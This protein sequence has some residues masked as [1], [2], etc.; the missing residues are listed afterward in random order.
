MIYPAVVRFD[1]QRV[2]QLHVEADP[3]LHRAQ[4]R[5]RE[6][7]VENAAPAP[8]ALPLAGKAEPRHQ[9][10]I[11]AFQRDEEPVVP[12]RLAELPARSLQQRAIRDMVDVEFHAIHARI[13]KPASIGRRGDLPEQLHIRLA[14]L[15]SEKTDRPRARP[16]RMRREM[17]ADAAR[18]FRQLRFCEREQTRPRQAAEFRLRHHARE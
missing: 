6:E 9:H 4:L 5:P 1:G 8:K 10:E 12:H 13:A 18:F 14:R 7:A 16:R 3:E 17:R 2:E 11:D 15:R